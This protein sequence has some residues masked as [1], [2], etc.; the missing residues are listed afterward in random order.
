M[1]MTTIRKD[2]LESLRAIPL[3]RRV[4]EGD[5]EELATH[6]IERRFPKNATV[7][8]EGLPGDYMYVIRQGRVKVTKASEDGREKIMNF[9]EAGAFFGDMALLGN[10][11][12]SASVKTLEESVLLALSRR[13]FID[14]LRQSPDLSLSVIEEL[15]NRLRETNEQARSLSFQGVEERTRNLFQRIARA[16]ESCGGRLI[17]PALTHQQI[18]DM[19]GTSRETVTRAIK[20]LKESGWLA[21][22][23]K[24]Y[25]IPNED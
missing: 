17:T 23:G 8:E 19:V 9:L 6:L 4:S 11:T 14:L 15:A 18:A 16:E 21:Q 24:R 25:V 20:Q 2:V 10:E 3:F 7:V 12:R 22:E 1:S 5:L 13:D